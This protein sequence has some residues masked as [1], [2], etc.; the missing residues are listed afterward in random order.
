VTTFDRLGQQMTAAID[1]C[2]NQA[3]TMAGPS[4]CQAIEGNFETT[5]QPLM[6]EMGQMSGSMDARMGSM[7]QSGMED[8]ACTSQGMMQVF[9]QH[10]LAA[11]T[12][13]D[14]AQNRAE[15]MMA[16]DQLGEMANHQQARAGR[17]GSMMGMGM[18]MGGGMMGS[19]MMPDG[20]MV[21]MC[22]A[23]D[24][25]FMMGGQTMGDTRMMSGS[26]G[27]MH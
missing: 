12:S 18:E 19:G 17:M 9:G 8:M 26:D 10:K 7:G 14:M 6:S 22:E 25:G 15:M 5:F 1:Q 20:G 11:C 16:M 27:G 4:D 23:L 24:G 13:S 21:P 2:R 3:S